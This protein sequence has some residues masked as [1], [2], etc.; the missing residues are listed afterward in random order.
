MPVPILDPHRD[1]ECPSC[2][3]RHRSFETRP[4]TPMHPCRAQGGLQVPFVPAG[5]V[6]AARHAVVVREDYVGGEQGV[7]FDGDGRPV[8]AVRTERRDGSNDVHV[9]AG[10]ATVEGEGPSGK[11]TGGVGQ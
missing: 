7:R 5:E 11:V 4:H 6:E 9:F 2:H 3:A 1:W 10:V 8:S